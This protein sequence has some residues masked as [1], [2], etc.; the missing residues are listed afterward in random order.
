M[1]K[2]R[3]K[4]NGRTRGPYVRQALLYSEE[5]NR[6]LWELER[7][8]TLFL[9]SKGYCVGSCIN[10]GDI[11]TEV[12]R[13]YHLAGATISMKRANRK[14]SRNGLQDYLLLEFASNDSLKDVVEKITD[15]FPGFKN[16][17]PGQL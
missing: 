9:G 8:L 12:C 1:A 3:G 7:D 5:G 16:T 15:Q 17:E 14:R 10:D 4:H 2:Y 13:A 6:S 11:Y